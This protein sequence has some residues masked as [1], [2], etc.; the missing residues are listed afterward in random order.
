V[1]HR[2]DR[3]LAIELPASGERRVAIVSDTHS[4]PH[5]EAYRWLRRDRPDAILHAGD[6]GSLHVLDELEDIAP[7][8]AVRG[9]IDGVDSRTPD[10]LVIN[11][12]A[13]EI[14]VQI[15]LTHIAVYGPKLRKDVRARARKS[16]AGLVVCGHSHVPLI[17]RD[18]EL[19]V[20]TPGSCGPRRF[21]LPITLGI[22]ELAS[23]G[24]QLRHIDCENGQPWLPPQASV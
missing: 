20:F 8:Y 5:P 15:L 14:C 4:K 1:R 11:L 2:T 19:A 10:D 9:N 6:I 18:G 12:S 24:V 23:K 13:G 22:L 16:G 7:T 21:H 17:A 3:T